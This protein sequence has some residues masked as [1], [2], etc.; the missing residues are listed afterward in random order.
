M[1]SEFHQPGE[2]PG[3]PAALRDSVGEGDCE[4]FADLPP[5]IRTA[6]TSLFVRKRNINRTKR[7]K[8][9]VKEHKEAAA[10]AIQVT[11]DHPTI[12]IG[13]AGTL[14]PKIATG[15]AEINTLGATQAAGF[16]KAQTGAGLRK[17]IAA[18]LRQA[19]VDIAALG[20]VLDKTVHPGLADTLRIGKTTRTYQALMDVGGAFV[21]ALTPDAMKTLFTE[22][23]FPATF[24]TDVSGMIAAMDTATNTKYGGIGQRVNCTAMLDDAAS[25]L[26]LLVRELDGIIAPNLRLTNAGLYSEWKTAIRL[27][28]RSKSKAAPTSAA[29]PVGANPPAA[30]APVT[31]TT[32]TPAA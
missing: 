5:A 10:R 2:L 9:Q 21:Q 26:M 18:K 8:T 17:D 7:M 14:I 4:H 1:F 29:T 27:P 20:R 23:G 16:K 12:L 11:V 13:T 15:I 19:L 6:I 31:P 32:A 25:R 28:A 3:A 24:L 30:P 22:R